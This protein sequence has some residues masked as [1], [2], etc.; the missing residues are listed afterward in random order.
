MELWLWMDYARTNLDTGT[1][2]TDNCTTGPPV[3]GAR[4]RCLLRLLPPADD[5]AARA[6][7]AGAEGIQAQGAVN[8]AGQGRVRQAE[9]ARF[10]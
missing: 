6:K 8:T 4:R 7:R 1:R 2:L 9:A 3:L 5:H 10:G